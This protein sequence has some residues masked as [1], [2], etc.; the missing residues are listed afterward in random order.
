M[1]ETEDFL[2]AH[3]LLGG[4]SMHRWLACPGSFRL[5]RDVPPRPAS[6]YAATGTVAHRLIE[7]AL[8]KAITQGGISRRLV[9]FDDVLGRTC[10]QDDHPVVIDDAMV[11]SVGVAL[12]HIISQDPVWFVSELRVRLDEYFK[13]RPSPPPVR[14]FGHVDVAL[15]DQAGDL[16]V[17]DYK[18]GSGIVIEIEDNPQ[19]LYYAAGTL[20]ELSR[21]R[22][23]LYERVR[24]VKLT[25]V[26]P[27][28]RH[29]DKIRSWTVDMLDVV[30][31]AQDVLVPAV[32][33]CA[34]PDAPLATGD[35]CRFC[36]VAHA[37]PALGA[38]AV[39]MAKRDF[40]DHVLPDTPDTLAEALI[41]AELAEVWIDAV[42]AYAIEKLKAD[43]A[44]V[45]GWGLGPTRPL[46]RWVDETEVEQVL[47]MLRVPDDR[48]HVTTLLSPAQMEKALKRH[49]QT[50]DTWDR[51]L[52]P[53][54][55]SQSSGVKLVRQAQDKTSAAADF[56]EN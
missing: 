49:R 29:R 31:W 15:I 30:I 52:V 40:A 32:E 6:V 36:P 21:T 8:S 45:T 4:S 56:S 48:T 14:L 5:S 41:T 17:V 54:V 20:A 26:Q 10:T 1:A 22:P 27:N 25:V 2:P 24:S 47:R 13:K 38:K 51:H 35:H 42:R 3:S 23:D 18:H 39:E 11:E 50:Q 7:H 44:A 43:P 28:V 16:E 46:R 34:E 55:K 12:M 33:R 19:L 37:C 9:S 53:F